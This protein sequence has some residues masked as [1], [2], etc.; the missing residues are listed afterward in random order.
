LFLKSWRGTVVVAVVMPASVIATFALLRWSGFTLNILTLT[1]LAMTIGVLVNNSIL[2]VE[3]A[4]TLIEKGMDPKDAAV[5]G[6]K[7]IV[8]G[9][10]GATSTNV[11]VFLPVA[12][13]G[14]IIGRF[15][16]ELG[17]TVVYSTMVS[18]AIAFSLTPM[19]CAYMLRSSRR[20]GPAWGQRLSQ[21]TVGWIADLWLTVYGA[22][23]RLFMA[24]LDWCL[25]HPRTTVVLSGLS[26]GVGV[27]ILGT[28]GTEFMPSSDEGRFRVTVQMPAGTPLS[29]SDAVVRRVEEEVKQ[30]PYL[31]HYHV[32]VGQ[33]SG[34]LGGSSG[35]VNLAEVS[36]TV[37]DRA[38]RPVTVD[39]LMNRLR[40]KLSGIPSARVSVES[41]AHGPSASPVMIEISGDDLDA[42]RRI[43]LQVMGIV[44]GV[45]GTASVAKSWQAGQP[46]V[47]VI[48]KQEEANRHRIDPRSVA[49]EVRS[50]VEGTTASQFKDRDENY[51]VQVKLS[52][53]D[54]Q[55]AGDVST[56]F[57]SSP[58]SGQMIPIGQVAEVREESGPTLITR[59]DRRRLVTVSAGLTGERSLGEVTGD[60]AAEVNRRVVLP[61]G[62]SISYAGEVESMQKNFRELFKALAIAGALTFLCTA[63][64]IE[65]FLFGAVIMLTVPISLICVSLFM[66]ATGVTVNVFALMGMIAQVGMVVNN[67]IIIVEYAMRQ[68]GSGR[69][70]AEIVRDACDARYRMIFMTNITNVVALIPL[71]LGLGF[72]GEIFR[73]LAIVGMAGSFGAWFLSMLV[74]PAIYV[75]VRRRRLDARRAAG[76]ALSA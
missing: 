16:K 27:A 13:M 32:R 62:V 59:K 10:L 33:V 56:M 45:K 49:G 60:I 70:A 14:E 15:F 38:D 36:V 24:V 1:G 73:P 47:R 43:G 54:R 52:D 71:A 2:I 67:A 65:S 75:L 22:G 53:A 9:I 44:E 58:A 69:S 30:V 12:F 57:I 50:Y 3:D 74:I 41:A 46:E 40:P 8:V 42:L 55:S 31:E 37:C 20:Q 61:E 25:V 66:L 17:L 39:D 19:M 21:F 35:G 23:K 5:V 51:D 7:D 72:A 63:G 26:V 11:V 4:S 18:L 28:L 6:T 68:E 48:P 64:I 76:P 34:F 29:V